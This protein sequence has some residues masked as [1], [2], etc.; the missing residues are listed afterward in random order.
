MEQLFILD[1]MGYIFRSYHAI[2]QM[3]NERGESTNA[4]FGFVRSVEKLFKDFDVEH[5]VAVFDGPRNDESRKKIY[6]A[7]KENRGET[8]K[9]LLYQFEWARQY[10]ELR[11]IATLTVEGVEADD[12]MA[13]VATWAKGKGYKALLLSGDKDLCQLV[14]DRIHILNTFKENL[15]LDPKGVEEQFGVPP[16]LI[17]DYLALVGDSS[18]NVPGVPGIGPK[19]AVDL[20]K[21]YG[22]LEAVL[23]NAS[24]IK[25][26]KGEALLQ[27]K[28]L[29]ILSRQLVNLHL[30]VPFPQ[31]D[32]FFLVKKRPKEPLKAFFHEQNFNSLI[33]EMG[34]HVAEELVNYTLIN[35]LEE[36]K[37]LVKRLGSSKEL[38]VDTET[39]AQDPLLAQLVGIGLGAQPK[40]AWYIPVNGSIGKRDII[41]LLNPLFKEKRLIG[42][43]IKY[44]MHVLSHFGFSQIVPFFDTMIASYLL[45]ADER[46]HGL[47][48]LALKYFEKVKIPI[49]SLIGK[50]K[51]EI[52]M[53][54]VAIESVSAYCCEDVDYTL[55]LYQLFSQELEIRSLR[56]LFDT[57]EM[58]LIPVLERME[59][60][61]VF[62]DK[63]VL[64]Q[65]SIEL[66]AKIKAL[67]EEIQTLASEPFNVNSPKQLADILFD[68][69]GIKPPK[70]TKTGFSTNA[71]VLE[72]LKGV[73]PIIEKVL[74]YR[75]LEK[76]RSTYIDT[77]PGQI[78]PNTHRVHCTF[79][80][81]VAATGRLSAQN[82]NLQNI[83]VRSDLGKKIRSAF[84]PE[85]PN[86]CFLGADYSQIELRLLAHLSEDPLLLKA[87]EQG[88]DVH[89]S[90]AAA[91]FGVKPE[92]VTPILRHQAKAVNFG[93]IYGQQA[94]GLS[95]ELGMSQKEAQAFIEKYFKA[96]AGVKNYVD[97]MKEEAK[98]CGC[99][100]TLFGRE[101]LLPEIN[102]QNPN[103]RAGA[104]RLAINTPLQGSNA[105]LIKMAMCQIDSALKKGGYRGAMILQIHDEL[106]FELPKEEI[107][108]VAA[109]VKKLM[110]GVVTL[111][112]PLVVDIAVGKNWAE[113]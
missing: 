73:H 93:I 3:T 33:K 14:D 42:H 101:R 31:E 104:E 75:T 16:H 28:E 102:S 97:R 40:E 98:R 63:D 67:Q 13:S 86:W 51:E 37:E 35:T 66:T 78:N 83:P 109:L 110:E 25:G 70:K 15:I 17:G 34:G 57:I 105:D 100:K 60:R 91:V 47:D 103:I 29:A 89:R 56:S 10:C 21:E 1:V 55:R 46:Q 53:D 12:T 96:Y 81:S 68:K 48:H 95:Q 8:P 50:G 61:G 76:L 44:D 85:N 26:K 39:T 84:R 5:L 11:G 22:S 111:K 2:R 94:W 112:V 30:D 23:S 106:L 69:L 27:N 38:C 107:E 79:N 64:S 77:L 6:S 43:N 41:E 49:E 59:E 7:Y 72:S 71:D 32:Q 99:A 65:L 62:V 36:L 52:T 19:G 54:Q 58:P 18:D 88:E 113:C 108:P 45:N 20:L 90:T 92:E 80:Q 9:D 87:F 74:E 4:L 82:P 24:H